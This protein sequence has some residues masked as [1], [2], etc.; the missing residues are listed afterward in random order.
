MALSWD[1]GIMS[2]AGKSAI[3]EAILKHPHLLL[4]HSQDSFL[5]LLPLTVA[6]GPEQLCFPCP[7]SCYLGDIVRLKEKCWAKITI[8][9]LKHT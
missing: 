5:P 3:L 2:A 7:F 6:C 4:L 8:L 1:I 9:A